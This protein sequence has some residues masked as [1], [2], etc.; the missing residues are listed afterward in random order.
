MGSH[1]FVQNKLNNSAKFIN[2]NTDSHGVGYVFSHPEVPLSSSL[3][4]DGHKS[5]IQEDLIGIYIV[6]FYTFSQKYNK[7]MFFDL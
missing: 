1:I 3:R 2:T 6:Y 5:T 4:V 7:C